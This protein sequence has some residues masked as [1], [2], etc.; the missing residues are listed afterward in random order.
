M[1]PR[2]V[3]LRLSNPRIKEGLNDGAISLLKDVGFQERDLEINNEKIFSI[4]GMPVI[5]PHLFVDPKQKKLKKEESLMYIG[6]KMT[7]KE[8][9]KKQTSS[10]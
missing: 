3:R 5:E 7:T 10:D 8:F 2:F 1:D 4:N 9:F 6:Q